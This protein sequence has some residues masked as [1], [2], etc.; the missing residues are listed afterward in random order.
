MLGKVKEPVQEIYSQTLLAPEPKQARLMPQRELSLFSRIP[1][2]SVTRGSESR[3]RLRAAQLVGGASA[4]SRHWPCCGPLGG[5]PELRGSRS[6]LWERFISVRRHLESCTDI[7]HPS[8]Q[9]TELLSG[10]LASAGCGVPWPGSLDVTPFSLLLKISQPSA[11]AFLCP[12]TL[13]L[14]P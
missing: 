12:A 6:A 8:Q 13:F 9:W 7:C 5:E 2:P 3:G 4:V 14:L 1:L 11:T 10:P